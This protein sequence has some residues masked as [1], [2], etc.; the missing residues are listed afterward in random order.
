MGRLTSTTPLDASSVDWHSTAATFTLPLEFAQRTSGKKIEIGVIA[1][2]PGANAAPSL[3]AVYA[4]Q[5]AGNSGWKA[6]ALTG[7][8]QLIKFS[9]DVPGIEGG[10]QNSPI[11]A[12]HSDP[13]GAGHAVEILG[14]FVRPSNDQ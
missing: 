10:Y 14:A 4:T 5:Q 8:F 3:Y 1:R 9:Y 6:L 13:Q 2:S 12:F 7:E 11:I